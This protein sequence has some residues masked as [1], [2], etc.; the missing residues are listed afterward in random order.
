VLVRHAVAAV[1]VGA[2]AVAALTL[3]LRLAP[4]I[5]LRLGPG[6]RDYAQGFAETFRFDGAV[7]FRSVDGRARVALPLRLS[8]GG[9]LEIVARSR[10]SSPATLAVRF[11]DGSTLSAT[12]PASEDFRPIR[13]EIPTSR[14]R[15]HV[16]LRIEGGP[17]DVAALRWRPSSVLPDPRLALAAGLLGAFSYLAF[18]AAG[19]RVLASLAGVAVLFGALGVVARG[20]ALAALHL[21]SRLPWAAGLG[22]ILV[23]IARIAARTP[24][25]RAL[26]FAGLL[27]KASLLFHPSFHFFDWQIHETLLELLYHRGPLDFRTRLVDYQL[28]HNVGVGRVGGEARVFPYPV[29][30]YY[31]A[32]LGNRFH[33]APE[34]WLKLTAAGFA[35]LALLPL[36]YVA[37][38]LVAEPNADLF[39]AVAY[40]AT[41]SLTRSLLLLELSAIAG[42]FFDLSAVAVLAALGLKLEGPRRFAAAMLAIAASLAAYTAGFVHMG[43]LSGSAILLALAGL[44]DRRD[45]FRLALAGILALGLSLFAYHPKALAAL[46]TA[47]L[48]QDEEPASS[49]AAPPA[50]RFG[51]AV[52]RARTFLGIPLIA[53][54]TLGLA[55]G[56]RRLDRS[57]IRTLFVAWGLSALVAYGLRYV[58]TDLFLYQKELYWAAALLAVGV[59]ALAATQRRPLAAGLAI[60]ATLVVSYAL[61]LR[62]ML[63]QFFRDYL[64]L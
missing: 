35:A 3:S 30:F 5:D 44:W 27:F 48:S 45:A 60:G 21:A 46:A 51:S 37:R 18:A 12:V 24:P 31:T 47:V 56:L 57:P 53:G 4:S 2:A 11:D 10:A 34:L 22:L 55:I 29:L 59:G 63:D 52:A 42:C 62:V 28:A 39:A 26:V 6:D 64:F 7:T 15:A 61:E 14:M 40:L 13:W 50:D 49:P 41:P 43:L 58:L 20:D 33:H 8:G 16:R 9:A 32:H 17:L 1:L 25:F 23:G 36:G 54:G 19:L 38:K